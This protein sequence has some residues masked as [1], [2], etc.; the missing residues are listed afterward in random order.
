MTLVKTQTIGS[1]VTTVT[2]NDAFNA[3]YDNYLISINGGAGSASNRMEL[4]LGASTTGYYAT[5]Q[6]ISYPAG[7]LATRRDDNGAAFTFSG[8]YS[9]NGIVLQM[10]LQNPYLAKYTNV[11]NTFTYADGGEGAGHLQGTH[12]V[13]TS[14]TSFKI[15]TVSGAT[16]TGGTI[17]VYGYQNS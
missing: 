14:Y 4:Q 7:T 3:T 16:L 11:S 17:R 15:S 9:A 6:S 10:S 2:V 8:T 12:A 13:A 1:A 5:G